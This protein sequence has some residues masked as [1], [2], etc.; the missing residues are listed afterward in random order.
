MTT[1]LNNF[2][3][4]TNGTTITKSNTG[5]ASGNAF[6][7][8]GASGTGAT[9]IF[10]STHTLHGEGLSFKWQTGS[11]AVA[12][13]AQWTTSM[14]SQSTIFGRM[15]VYNGWTQA[16]SASVRL[17]S[18]A[19]SGGT[20]LCSGLYMLTSGLLTL[21]D[22]AS[23]NG[24]TT[25]N[26]L[27]LNAWCRIEFKVF[28]SATVGT[29]QLQLYLNP[30]SPTPTENLTATS[31]NTSAG[32]M[33]V[34]DFG[35][36]FDVQASI[37]P[38]WYA[39]L[40]LSSTAFLGPTLWHTGN[41][42]AAGQPPAP[43][44]TPVQAGASLPSLL[45][46][47]AQLLKVASAAAKTVNAGLAAATGTAYGPSVFTQSATDFIL[48]AGETVP[49][50]AVQAGASLPAPLSPPSQ[51]VT[52]PPIITANAGLATATGT[53]FGPSVF[54]QSATVLILSAEAASSPDSLLHAAGASLATPLSAAQQLV[55]RPPIVTVNAGLAHATGIAFSPSPLA[56]S[57]TDFIL[58]AGEAIP[59][60]FVD[61]VGASL[62]TALS[63]PSRIITATPVVTAS[64]GLA[65]ATGTAQSPLP[66]IGAQPSLAHATGTAQQPSVFTQS[67]TSFILTA[68][69][70]VPG[71]L[72]RAAGAS[73]ATPLSPASRRI[74]VPG[75]AT[76]TAGLAH[77]TGTAQSPL[78]AIGA[79]AG[80]AHAAGTAQSPQAS[81][82]QPVGYV[83]G[84]GLPPVPDLAAIQAGASLAA[85]LSP[86]SRLV[87][88][89]PIV[90][91]AAG[92]A[93]ATGTAQSPQAGIGAQPSLAHATGT[94]QQPSV[95][96]LSPVTLVL[97]GEHQ[98]PGMT[99]PQAGA[100]LA[101]PLS[102]ASH[103][104]PVPP[105][106]T[107]N[108]GLATATGTA[109]QPRAAIGV[110]AALAHATGAS[111]SPSVFTQS[112]TDFV[113]AAG[114]YSPDS[115]LT[116]TGQSLAAPLSPPSRRI[117]VPAPAATASAG[118][119]HATGTA[120]QPRAAIAAEP[121]AAHATG[122]GQSPQAGAGAKPGLAHG[123]GT[124]YG[125]APGRTPRLATATGAA[126]NAQLAAAAHAQAVTVLAVA[127][128]AGALGN[129]PNVKG[130]SRSSV[131]EAAAM[132]AVTGEAA[133][134]TAGVAAS[135]VSA[136]STG[137]AAGMSANI[138]P[139]ASSQGGVT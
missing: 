134:M 93:H 60:S 27:P 132:Q 107:V 25:T 99:P 79:E 120:Q 130:T 68:G 69:A 24:V 59:N 9:E 104:I 106:G 19:T 133:A 3:G 119:A 83:L 29:V 125:P 28:T 67:A 12:V 71:S 113:L 34:Y 95:A 110:N 103:R 65:H 18:L 139:G 114:E 16:P 5:G 20:T 30:D 70:A 101:T 94:A 4:G 117:T 98:S 126:L 21:T 88:A 80:L 52:R 73:L 44:L 2:S 96:A 11:T 135:G 111:Q 64:A 49:R 48:A 61:L 33:A 115:I 35:Q 82:F 116:G 57:A 46:A 32:P 10:D 58:N 22:T 81:V 92:L 138:T 6:N 62:A 40:G 76:T 85:P 109:L 56:Q 43:S 100:S 15:Y 42:L 118:L 37:G 1:L 108:A 38:F 77:A 66:A 129:V 75:V 41:V 23:A 54:T 112:V 102:P 31:Q 123:T 51:L 127:L 131:G 137:E 13:G 26:K 72:D 17:M 47:G 14:G 84:S 91:P 128:N 97:T 50:S 121:S 36:D 87:T 122:T 90:T 86:R 74:A 45:S 53:A 78:A 89:V 124:A 63:P 39:D 8:V 136:S 55:T 7:A 105:V